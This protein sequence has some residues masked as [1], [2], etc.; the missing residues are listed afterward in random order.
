M[1][2]GLHFGVTTSSFARRHPRT[3][4]HPMLH[5]GQASIRSFRA[6]PN[7]PEPLRPL[8][9]IAHNLW[10]TWHPEAVRLF[11]RLDR[12]LWEQTHHNPVKLLGMV[13]QGLLDRVAK[14][15]SF[16]PRRESV[17]RHSRVG[18][19]ARRAVDRA[20]V[21]GWRG[22]CAGALRRWRLAAHAV[23]VAQSGRDRRASSGDDE[24]GV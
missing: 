18:P 2:L 16:R 19:S 5:A 6:V 9:E 3:P 21:G 12:D 24:G 7:L 14:D 23:A 15:Q 1:F 8:M 17:R 20:R 10:W 22:G 13:D 4:D 11:Q